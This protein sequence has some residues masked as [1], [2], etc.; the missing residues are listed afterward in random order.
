MKRTVILVYIILLL[1][2]A[3]S[4]TSVVAQPPTP[5]PVYYGFVYVGGNRAPDGLN[6]T[7]VISGTSIAWTTFT[8]NGLRG[9]YKI[10]T[11][12]N[13][14]ATQKDGAVEGDTIKFYVNGTKTNQTA[15]WSYI[16]ETIKLDLSIPEISGSNSNAYLTVFADCPSAYAGYKVKISGRLAYTNGTGISGANLSMTY[17]VMNGISWNNID[18]VNTT[19]DGGYYAEWT[20]PAMVDYLIKVRWE[21]NETLNLGGT[22]AY[23]SV[24]TVPLEEKYVFS[25]VSNSTIFLLTFNSSSGVLDFGVDG[26]SGTTGYANVTISKDLIGETAGLKVYLDGNQTYYTLIST[27]T[28]WLLHLAYQHSTHDVT[29]NLGSAPPAFFETLLGMATLIGFIAVI[30]VV[31]AFIAYRKLKQPGNRTGR[32]KPLKKKQQS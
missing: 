8:D 18:S 10:Q 32:E 24:A 26:P 9:N 16:S 25:V 29:V 7:A 2:S 1:I 5:P 13:D 15:I 6:V 17:I 21:G 4:L 19:I 20:P 14:N 12:A 28:S 23:V 11:Q 22:E 27:D 30:I 31:V 3:A